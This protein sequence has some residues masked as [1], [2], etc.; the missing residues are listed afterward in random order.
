MSSLLS[1][2]F[3]KKK[4]GSCVIVR[5]P[6]VHPSGRPAGLQQ[7]TSI[8]P[9]TIDA[10]ITKPICMIPLCIQMVA[11]YLKFFLVFQFCN[12]SDFSDFTP[13]CNFSEFFTKLVIIF[14]CMRVSHIQHISNGFYHVTFGSPSKMEI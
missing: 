10:R 14:K 3:S 12:N 4:R 5:R 9:Y 11:T 7:F 2:Q 1:P 13:K 6:S 8:F